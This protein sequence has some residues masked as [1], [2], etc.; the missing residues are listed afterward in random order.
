[1]CAIPASPP[2]EGGEARKGL[3]VAKR[4]RQGGDAAAG[5]DRRVD[6]KVSS[7]ATQ[8]HLI[9]GVVLVLCS[10]LCLV[11]GLGLRI[12]WLAALVFFFGVW[13][14]VELG[15]YLEFRLSGAV[16]RGTPV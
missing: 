7:Q 12:P 6:V 15:R 5:P 16:R 2:L 1:V 9:I 4:S 3:E 11:A 8:G 14:G 10:L 13:G